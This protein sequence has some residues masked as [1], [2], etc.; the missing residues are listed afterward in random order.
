MI[1]GVIGKPDLEG[2]HKVIQ[3]LEQTLKKYKAELLAED[4]LN[5][6]PSQP[7][8]FIPRYELVKKS[9]LLLFS[10]EM[11]LCCMLQKKQL[12]TRSQ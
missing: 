1:V 8:N 11:E 10:E 12:S 9:I 4:I 2:F 5:V 7:P 6:A 3:N